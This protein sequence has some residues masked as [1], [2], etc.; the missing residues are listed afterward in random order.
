M[1]DK[2]KFFHVIE[3]TGPWHV[4]GQEIVFERANTLGLL[5]LKQRV[6]IEVV[7]LCRLG[8]GR[9]RQRRGREGSANRRGRL[10]GRE[11]GRE[12]ASGREFEPIWS[13]ATG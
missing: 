1:Q 9:R 3:G 12:E 7:W 5:D 4:P 11:L 6:A 2:D 10:E 8:G 13:I